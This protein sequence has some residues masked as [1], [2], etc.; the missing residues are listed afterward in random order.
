VALASLTSGS[1]S[2]GIVHGV[3][4]RCLRNVYS[5]TLKMEVAGASETFIL[6]H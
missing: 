5:S 2:V 4:F 1:R 3:Q 6:L